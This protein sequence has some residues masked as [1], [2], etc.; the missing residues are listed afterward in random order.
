MSTGCN[1]CSTARRGAMPATAVPVVTVTARFLVLGTI[2]GSEACSSP[3]LMGALAVDE[4]SDDTAD[5]GMALEPPVAG[6][7]GRTEAFGLTLRASIRAF[8]CCFRDNAERTY[9]EK[10]GMLF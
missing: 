1:L 4:G 3:L 5:W 9:H 10:K 8:C 7:V 2:W 6:G